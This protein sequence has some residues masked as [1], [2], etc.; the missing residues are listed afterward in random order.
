MTRRQRIVIAALVTI[1]GSA[2]L[3]RLS[4]SHQKHTFAAAG[5]SAVCDRRMKENFEPI[6]SADVLDRVMSIPISTWNYRS[7]DESIRHMGPMAQDFW[8]AFGLGEDELRIN[9]IDAS[10][11]ALA[12][13]QG[14]GIRLDDAQDQLDSHAADIDQLRQVVE[15]Q[16]EDGGIAGGTIGF[17]PMSAV[18]FQPI[19]DTIE[20]VKNA[21]H[22]RGTNSGN[23]VTF[24]APIDLPHGAEV[25]AF[26]AQV[27]DNDA[28]QNVSL[29]LRFVTDTGS[30]G[31]MASLSST[32]SAANVRTFSTAAITQGEFVDNENRCYQV[33]AS[34]TVPPTVTNIK[35]IRVHVRYTMF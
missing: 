9:S 34:W 6:D 8:P 14:L 31:A 3:A 5:A 30:T 24:F 4:N 13:I 33:S 25:T 32:G 20:F 11:V 17:A 22:V 18:G 15:Q 21:D 29:F 2:A 16:G 27:V 19:N 26:E 35:L 12:A 7:Q 28:A 1:P 23:L 10:G